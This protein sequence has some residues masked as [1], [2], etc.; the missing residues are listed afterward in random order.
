MNSVI[1]TRQG[2]YYYYGRDVRHKAY[3]ESANNGS[4]KD[5]YRLCEIGT[6]KDI[7]KAFEW[8]SISAHNG[9]AKSQT[10]LGECYYYG[11]DE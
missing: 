4:A 7:K 3:S 11:I 8:Y 2:D 9:C 10:S 5:Q 1:M 6:D